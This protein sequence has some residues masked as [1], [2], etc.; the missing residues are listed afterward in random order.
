MQ[1]DRAGLTN[2]LLNKE[3]Q[4]GSIQFGVWDSF[5]CLTSGPVPDKPQELLASDKFAHGLDTLR[6]LYDRIIIDCAPTHVVND[7]IVIGR[8]VDEVLFVV[9]PHE[10]PI[11]L[12]KNGLSRLTEAQ[13]SIAGICISRVDFNKS[14]SYGDMEFDGFR[15]SFKKYK[16]YYTPGDSFEN[17]PPLK[18]TAG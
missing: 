8:L 7:A 9:K 5:D 6:K 10:T 3:I 14:K 18:L 16:K 4:E 12:V 13:V 17:P 15:T 2:L 1:A 11:K